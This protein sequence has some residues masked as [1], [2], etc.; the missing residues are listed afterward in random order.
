MSANLLSLAQH[1][2]AISQLAGQFLGESQGPT[3]SVLTPLLP[4]VLGG[5]VQKGATPDGAGGL[6]SLINGANL[7]VNLLGNLAGLFGGGGSGVTALLK[8]ERAAWCRRC[9]ATRAGAG[10]CAVIEQWDQDFV[11][12]QSAG[13]G[14]AVVARVPEEVHRR[15][16]PQCE[17]LGVAASRPRTELAGCAGQPSTEALG[18]ASRRRSL[19][20]SPAGGGG[21]A[22]RRGCGGR[23]DGGCGQRGRRRDDVDQVRVH[24]LV[25]VADRGG[26]AALAVEHVRRQT[27]PDARAR[28]GAQGGRTGS[29]TDARLCRRFAAGQG[30][31]RCR[32][33]CRRCG[34]RQGDCGGR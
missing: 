2:A 7:D 18:F 25:A 6:L 3:Q 19:A 30:L 23:R 13:D 17:F 20:A 11:G 31:L 8:T 29:S 22:P 4:A 27:G 34:R 24:A 1:W 33:G 26:G 10:E 21:G 15:Q 16:R 12:D 32:R 5:I 14:G 9:S 28:S